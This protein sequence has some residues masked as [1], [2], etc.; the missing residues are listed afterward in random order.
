MSHWSDAAVC[1]DEDHT[2]S[3][4]SAAISVDRDALSVAVTEPASNLTVPRCTPSVVGGGLPLFP[5]TIREGISRDD[6]Q[7]SL[8]SDDESSIPGL[9]RRRASDDD[10]ST[11]PGL[12]SAP[13]SVASSDNDAM[14]STVNADSDASSICQM[15]EEDAEFDALRVNSVMASRVPDRITFAD[16]ASSDKEDEDSAVPN[17]MSYASHCANVCESKISSL[18]C[19]S[20]GKAGRHQAHLDGG[21]QASTTNDRSALWGCKEFTD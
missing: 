11:V 19:A 18:A 13:S 5:S 10:D 16:D 7:T 20:S 6:A 21:S 4:S 3:G 17:T 1:G 9:T 2:S 12:N 15:L 8:A 14:V